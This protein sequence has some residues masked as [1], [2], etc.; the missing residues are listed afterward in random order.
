[1]YITK[2]LNNNYQNVKGSKIARIISLCQQ[3]LKKYCKVGQKHVFMSLGLDKN[4][5][6]FVKLHS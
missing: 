3:K 2:Q 5:I 4:K 1:M 6:V